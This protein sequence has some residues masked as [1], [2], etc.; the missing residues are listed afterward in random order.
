MFRIIYE[1]KVKLVLSLGFLV[2][3]TLPL[4]HKHDFGR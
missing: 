1:L 2:R 3:V 4:M